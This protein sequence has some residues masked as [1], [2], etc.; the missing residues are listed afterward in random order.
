MIWFLTPHWKI[1]KWVKL[2]SQRILKSGCNKN[3]TRVIATVGKDLGNYCEWFDNFWY[4]EPEFVL[5]NKPFS[6]HWMKLDFLFMRAVCLGAADDDIIIFLD[7]DAFPIG[8]EFPLRIFRILS[9]N[10]Y[11]FIQ[12]PAED[13]PHPAFFAVRV[14]DWRS[15]SWFPGPFMIMDS[16][17]G[18]SRID[19]DIGGSLSDYLDPDECHIL[20]H[21]D[22]SFHPE[23]FSTFG[24]KDGS[25]V[26]HHG[27]SFRKHTY[28]RAERA[29]GCGRDQK[30][31]NDVISRDVFSRLSKGEEFWR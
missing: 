12:E 7:G 13:K 5:G 2:Q 31:I 24:D 11:C 22:C 30:G 4:Y 3:N 6:N 27:A 20:T 1:D 10:N 14:K 16:D 26:Y 9:H 15:L 8:P 28:S 25:L 29:A 19:F 23:F 21:K 18:S 17:G